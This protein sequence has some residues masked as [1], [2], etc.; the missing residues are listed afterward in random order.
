MPDGEPAAVD[1]DDGAADLPHRARSSSRTSR[2]DNGNDNDTED[3]DNDVDPT[4]TRT[5][6][7]TRTPTPTKTPTVRP[8]ATDTP[9]PTPTL[10]PPSIS[11]IS[12]ELLVCGQ[13]LTLHGQR[14]GESRSLVSGKVRIDR[15]DA[16]IVTWSMSEVK[17]RVPQAA[18]PGNSRLL[19]IVV[20]EQTDDRTVRVSC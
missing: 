6:T 12:P 7:R 14:F 16:A 17:V 13:D 8:T 19:E 5:P 9:V 2:S 4:P 11:S 1:V 3:N 20:A 15:V 10:A 18:R